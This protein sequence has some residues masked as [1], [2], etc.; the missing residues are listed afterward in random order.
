MEGFDN[1]VGS[2]Y[3][4][5]L[6]TMLSCIGGFLFG[7]DTGIISG[8]IIFIQRDFQLDSQSQELIVG[9]TVG[10]ALLSSSIAGLLSDWYGRKV[11]I[12]F[13][14]FVFAIGAVLMSLADEIEILLLGRFITGLAVGIASFAMPIYVSEAAPA[15]SRGFLVTCINV[16][17]TLGQLIAAITA[18]ILS[19]TPEGWRYM[20]GL[21]AIPAF[22]QFAGFLMLPES[23]RWLIEKGMTDL[24]ILALQKLRD[25]DVRIMHRIF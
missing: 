22:F 1:P 16:A 6:L 2:L 4:M 13:S 15:P 24:A 3:Y 8:A 18:G 21:A 25:I 17:I 9:I 19:T 11:L 10:G 5:Y 23:P 20:L 7:Y 14:S 12:L